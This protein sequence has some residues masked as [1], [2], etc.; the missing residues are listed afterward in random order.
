MVDGHPIETHVI[1]KTLDD[2][3][4]DNYVSSKDFVDDILCKNLHHVEAK[5]QSKNGQDKHSLNNTYNGNHESN[6]DLRNDSN[7][8]GE[9]SEEADVN[10]EILIV[11]IMKRIIENVFKS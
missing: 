5:V 10:D 4:N 9:W 7:G 2:V 11:K 8:Q 6:E 1:D 3:F